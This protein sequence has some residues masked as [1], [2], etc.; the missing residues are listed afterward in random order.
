LSRLTVLFD[1][2]ME[3]RRGP[4]PDVPARFAAARW[5]PVL[6]A[7]EPLRRRTSPPQYTRIVAAK[8][9]GSEGGSSTPQAITDVCLL[10]HLGHRP[11][12]HIAL[13]KPVSA[14]INALV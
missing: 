11:T 3:P 13:A 2:L 1:L 4:L 12:S 5:R 6:V 8:L 7:F 9:S 14:P 10:T